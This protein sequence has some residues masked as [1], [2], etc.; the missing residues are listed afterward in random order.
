MSHPGLWVL[1]HEVGLVCEISWEDKLLFLM[2]F[3]GPCPNI[4]CLFSR[5]WDHCCLVRIEASDSA[6][7]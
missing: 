6:T 2:E 7:L 1:S 4:N 5:Q 3:P